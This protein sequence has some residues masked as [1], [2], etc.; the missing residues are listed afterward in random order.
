M[1]KGPPWYSGKMPPAKAATFGRRG[2]PAAAR[3]PTLS[4]PASRASAALAT[5]ESGIPLEEIARRI[6]GDGASIAETQTT[7]APTD[8][9][10]PWTWRA[11]ILAGLAAACLQAGLVVLSTQSPTPLLPG[12]PMQVGG[13]GSSLTPALIAYG[14]WNGGSA[15]ATTMMIANFILRVM[16]MT[17]PVAYALGGAL[18][19]AG[20]GYL[21][22]VLLGGED[23]MATDAIA[24]LAAGFLYRIFAGVKAS[25]A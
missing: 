23:T 14:L 11:A 20:S 4:T 16:K 22:R 1:A 25:K 24:G 19:G 8:G 17:S 15:A 13:T 7:T 9:V 3:A 21:L 10:V 2:A 12:L 6:L 5:T 18:V